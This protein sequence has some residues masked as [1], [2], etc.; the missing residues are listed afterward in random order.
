VGSDAEREQIMR[1]DLGAPRAAVLAR[2]LRIAVVT[3]LALAATAAILVFI[4]RTYESTARLMVEASASGSAADTNARVASQVELIKSRDLLLQVVDI[5]NLRSIPEFS[6]AGFSPVPMLMRLVGLGDKRSVDEI[7]MANLADRMTVVREGE[8]SV[9]A[10]TVRAGEPQL[11]AGIANRIARNHVDGW[12]ARQAADSAGATTRLQQEID[13]L[14]VKV[15]AADGAV[16]SYKIEHDLAD[17]AALPGLDQMSSTATSI[18]EAQQRREVAESRA[19]VIRG[20]LASGEPLNGVAELGNSAVMA[21]LMQSRA[22]LQAELTQRQTTLL[23][24]HPTIR[25]LKGQIAQVEGQIRAEAEKIAAS[26]EAEARIAGEHEKSL[27]DAA[28]TDQTAAGAAAASA[29]SLEG[30][31]REAKA[32]RD[33]LDS[34]LAKYA[35]LVAANNSSRTEQ[36]V[37]IISDAAP[38][39]E[40]ASPKYLLVMGAVGF[41]AVAL[42]VAAILLGQATSAPLRQ[43]HELAARPLDEMPEPP[44]AQ[45][46]AEA[47]A[48]DLVEAEADGVAEAAE[49]ADDELVG[50]AVVVDD[51]LAALSQDLLAQQQRIV[52]LAGVGRAA[53]T[54]LVIERVLED[55]I[56]EELS[57][58]VVDAGSGSVSAAV[59]LT[60]LA[61]GAVDYGEALQRVGEN[62]AE[63]QWGRLGTL[64]LQSSRPLTL[65]E[66]LAEIYHIVVVDTGNVRDGLNLA[67]FAGANA[68]VV[69]VPSIDT[70]AATIAAARQEI[71]ALGFTSSRVVHLAAAR[72]EVA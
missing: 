29:V 34:Y 60:D 6:N 50:Q 58:V 15:S 53:D 20:L 62:L 7:V 16:A 67:A 9:I 1:V 56:M 42:Q 63:V 25:A 10:I 55:T 32:Q 26:L 59:G 54:L 14:R 41:A 3:I 36:D 72:A 57:A 4:P 24:N 66:A 61:A 48:D 44:A 37:R 64:D 45:D 22:T 70:P 31:E 11:A 12:A 27:R 28:A 2:A 8:S 46:F 19:R 40:P 51:D 13:D 33:L 49:V 23:P 39:L 21:L 68:S 18:A 35:D 71:A 47:E 65:I 5:E 52:L 69:I 17:A 30:L 38:A 43:S